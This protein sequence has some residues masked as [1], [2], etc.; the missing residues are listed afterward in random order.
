MT[1]KVRWYQPKTWGLLLLTLMLVGCSTRIIYYWLD[2]A[3]IWQLDDY[4]ALSSS[5]KSL[6]SREVK[7]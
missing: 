3:I 6:L 1:N 5:Q 2:T 4:F 7:G